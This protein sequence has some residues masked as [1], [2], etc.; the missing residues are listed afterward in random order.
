MEST[1]YQI[2]DKMFKK[3]L[4]LSSLSVVNLINGLFGTDYPKDSKVS[5]NWT[6]F[7]KEDLR[8]ILADTILT[9][10]G[11]YSY[12]MEA[13]M[14]RDNAII[15]RVFDY[16]Y[17][18]ALRSVKEESGIWVLEFPEPKIIYLY[19]ENRIP[20]EY[21]LKL[22]FGTQ[23]EFTYRVSTFKYQEASI[24]ELNE[25]KMVILIPFKLLK[26]RKLLEK[27]RSK[28]NLL[29]LKNLIQN[30]IIGSIE[31][32]L[33]LGNITFQD[34]Q[35]LKRYT[36]KLYEHIYAHYK[37]M[38][39]L[40]EMTDESLMLDIDIIEKKHETELD[41]VKEKFTEKLAEK[42]NALIEKQNDLEKAESEIARLKKLLE[43]AGISS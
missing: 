42:E 26:L 39:E 14:D 27:D 21:A 37:E 6:E 29:A 5:Y 16:G 15:L 8:K 3:I 4:T 33:A 2:Y 19:A 1:I 10:N 35:K 9:I 22:E 36:H 32:N 28:D 25:K 20:D 13:Q 40:N 24:G 11:K 12:H 7:E 43:N 23:G 34:A 41:E 17:N 18:H 31:E 30:D 38:E